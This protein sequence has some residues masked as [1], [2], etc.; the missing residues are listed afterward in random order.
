[1]AYA[2][3]YHYGLGRRKCAVARVR[4]VPGDGRILVNGKTVADY[5]GR[6]ALVAI[7][8]QPLDEIAE[9]RRVAGPQRGQRVRRRRLAQAVRKVEFEQDRLGG[10]DEHPSRSQLVG[11]ASGSAPASERH[12]TVT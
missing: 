11:G 2:V 3:Q 9:Q 8:R 1:M 5:F 4:L 6:P 10:H 7:V 12:A